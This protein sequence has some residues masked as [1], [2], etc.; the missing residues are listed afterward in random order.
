MPEYRESGLGLS[1]DGAP[2]AVRTP[3][4]LIVRASP[5]HPSNVVRV[6]YA[7]DGGPQRVARGF[8]L[9][10][11][12]G[13]ADQRFAVDLPGLPGGARLEWRPVLSCSGRE[14]DPGRGG[15]R[16]ETSVVEAP[17][18][19]APRSAGSAPEA[20]FPHALEFLARV[21][22]PLDRLPEVIGETPEGL[23][24]TYPLAEG[25]TVRGPRLNGTILHRGGDWMR[26]RP[27][28]IGIADVRVLI[29]TDA[30]A[31]VM[32]EYSGVV[33]FG[34]DGYA[35]L[36]ARRPPAQ[37][38][39]QLTPRYVTAARELQW[40]NRLQ[41]V[42]LGRVTMKTLLVEYDLYARTPGAAAS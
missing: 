28:G 17:G 12:A 38:W 26:I 36:A 30:G 18:A 6:L 34:A 37:A 2:E 23:R 41:C 7:L 20:R 42:G 14:A 9:D 10:P 27:D 24:I 32:G 22:A 31:L 16:G 3:A 8:P 1:W 39:A 11:P 33:D 25:G 21:T 29:R 5:A 15:L 19:V 13:R 40:L 35:A 4:R